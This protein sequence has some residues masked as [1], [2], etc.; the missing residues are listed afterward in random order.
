MGQTPKH[1]Q[2]P[3]VMMAVSHSHGLKQCPIC[4]SNAIFL[5]WRAPSQL[6]NDEVDF[7]L[8]SLLLEISSST[9]QS[10]LLMTFGAKLQN[11]IPGLLP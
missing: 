6:P 3:E 8:G 4:R 2:L 9:L 10:P 1:N 7:V 5:Y 11:T